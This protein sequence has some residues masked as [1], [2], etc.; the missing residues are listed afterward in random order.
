M[1]LVPPLLVLESKYLHSSSCRGWNVC[2]LCRLTCQNCQRL[3][4]QQPLEPVT[5]WSPT[6]PC[7]SPCN[8]PNS[9]QANNRRAPRQTRRILNKIGS[10][11]C[12]EDSF[13]ASTGRK[14]MCDHALMLRPEKSKIKKSNPPNHRNST[15][16]PE[17]T[18]SNHSGHFRWAMS[19]TGGDDET[20]RHNV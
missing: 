17:L 6:Q 15:S 10:N 16:R 2:S 4:K 5:G 11:L 1:W 18:H 20:S 8:L 7:H 12:N 3:P 13:R 14:T 9:Y 19:E